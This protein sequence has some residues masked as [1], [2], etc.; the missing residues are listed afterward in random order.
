LL[1]NSWVKYE[2]DVKSGNYMIVPTIYTFDKHSVIENWQKVLEL[3]RWLL[4][5]SALEEK[6]SENTSVSAANY[7]ILFW[8]TVLK[9]WSQEKKLLIV[10]ELVSILDQHKHT[11]VEVEGSGYS[12]ILQTVIMLTQSSQ[13]LMTPRMQKQLVPIVGAI[14]ELQD[15]PS[16]LMQSL[17]TVFKQGQQTVQL[18]KLIAGYADLL[19]MQAAKNDKWELSEFFVSCYEAGE[20]DVILEIIPQMMD[21]APKRN[22]TEQIYILMALASIS[23]GKKNIGYLLPHVEIIMT[24]IEITS[25]RAFAFQILESIAQYQPE[26]LVKRYATFFPY[27]K[28]NSAWV[29][30]TRILGLLGHA[31]ENKETIENIVEA[32]F[33]LL[34]ELT[35]HTANILSAV[36]EVATGGALHKKIILRRRK[37][38]ISLRDGPTSSH[39]TSK[40]IENILKAIPHID[41]AEILEKANGYFKSNEMLVKEYQR[42]PVPIVHEAFLSHAQVDVQDAAGI[43]TKELSDRGVKVWYDQDTDGSIDVKGMILGVANSTVFL[44]F[45]SQQYFGRPFCVFELLVAQALKKNVR[46]VLERDLRHGGFAKFD[47]FIKSIP[48]NFRFILSNEAIDFE[49]RAFK[50]KATMDHIA[51]VLKG[52]K[53]DSEYKAA[54]EVKQNEAEEAVDEPVRKRSP[55]LQKIFGSRKP[56]TT[57]TTHSKSISSSD[58]SNKVEELDKRVSNIERQMATLVTIVQAIAKKNGMNLPTNL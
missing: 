6:F 42:N 44:I 54:E 12:K 3:L 48:G 7:L 52:G 13:L 5:K 19:V 57:T 10:D 38:L 18:R 50:K 28:D 41:H 35:Q 25:I 17:Q 16:D 46:I 34:E 26:A 33:I 2:A 21:K 45:A 27:M 32:L 22:L 43:L 51:A 1:D 23:K 9:L 58:H 55:F 24:F 11:P 31:S 14:L 8:L 53:G 20:K 56:K 15:P 29:F 36:N 37:D 47:D 40:M 30:A 39:D 49:R 4:S